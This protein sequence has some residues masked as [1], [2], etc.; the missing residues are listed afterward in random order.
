MAITKHNGYNKTTKTFFE[1]RVLE[2]RKYTARRNMSDT[3]DYT[4]FRDVEC[5]DALVWLG[6][7]GVPPHF[8]E[9]PLTRTPDEHSSYGPQPRELEFHEQFAWVDC[10]NHFSWRGE[11]I[12]TPT[13]DADLHNGEPLMWANYIAWKSHQEAETQRQVAEARAKY[14]E[15]LRLQAEAAKEEAARQAKDLAKKAVAEKL[16]STV[17]KGNTYT[18]DGFTGQAFW[19]GAK[20]YRGKWQPRVGLKNSRGEVAW[21]DASKLK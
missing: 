8:W 19:M 16:L 14:E 12:K 1:G 9:R 10:S 13:V 18:V 7:H 6:T 15:R 2:I 21:I 3:L 20:K 4:D 11:D 17:V 5:V